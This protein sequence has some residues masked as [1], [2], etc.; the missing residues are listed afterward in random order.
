MCWAVEAHAFPT[1][2]HSAHATFRRT[3]SHIFAQ[4]RLMQ[5]FATSVCQKLTYIV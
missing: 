3:E 4:M 5:K 2:P 1:K